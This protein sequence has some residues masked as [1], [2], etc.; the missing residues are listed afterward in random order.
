MAGQGSVHHAAPAFDSVRGLCDRTAVISLSPAAAYHA[1]V[2]PPRLAMIADEP[3]IT[4][5]ELDA[6][7]RTTAR[8]LAARGVGKGD[9]VLER[10]LRDARWAAV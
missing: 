6:R 3:R 4:Y 8:W 5:G 7:V 2:D 10:V 9:V 1:R